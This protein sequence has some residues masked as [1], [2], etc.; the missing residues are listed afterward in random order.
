[1]AGFCFTCDPAG[2]GRIPLEGPR[3]VGRNRFI[4]P[5]GEARG[6][7]PYG[8]ADGAIKRLR[9]TRPARPGACFFRRNA[10][11][12]CVRGPVGRGPCA[13]ELTMGYKVAVVG[14]T[15]NVGREMLAIL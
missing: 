4:A 8:E 10:L 15:G 9:P 14:A 2:C 5:L 7:A 13:G 1:M 11:E 12:A 6:I 3:I